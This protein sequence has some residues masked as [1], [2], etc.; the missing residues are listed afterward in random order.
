P[1]A[2]VLYAE[3]AVRWWHRRLE[4]DVATV[5][6]E[7]AR[8]HDWFRRNVGSAGWITGRLDPLDDEG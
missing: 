8:V 4:S 1:I 5:R 6:R 2:V 7:I 3:D